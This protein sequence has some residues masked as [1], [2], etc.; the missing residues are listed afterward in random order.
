[1]TDTFPASLSVGTWTCTATAGS[2][3]TV[4]GS[5]NN[6]TGTVTLLNGGS[7]TFTSNTTVSSSAAGSVS[8]TASVAVPAGT[9]DPNLANNSATDTDTIP[10]AD[11]SIT[12]TDNT[13]TALPGGSLTYVIVVSNGGPDAVIGATVADIF[14]SV[15]TVNS[16]TCTATAGSS[17]T[18]GGSANNRTGSVNLLNGGSA[19]YTANATLSASATGQLTNP[20]TVA[21]PAGVVDPNTGNNSANDTDFITALVHVGDLD[22]ISANSNATTWAASVTITVHDANHA[23]VALAAVSV[24]WTGGGSGGGSCVTN[25]SGVCT[26][27]RTGLSRTTVSSVTAQVTNVATLN[28]VYQPALNHDSDSGAQASNGTMITATRP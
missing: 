16:W 21:V 19:T 5:G 13:V 25:G 3:C 26:V 22:W 24:T 28:S 12:K 8:N 17:C 2:S 27:T 4:G 20:A 6:R 7:A 23:P 9:T 11:L 10:T 14:P 15:L 18:A 1:V